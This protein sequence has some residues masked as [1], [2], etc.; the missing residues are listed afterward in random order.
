MIEDRTESRI[1]GQ[2]AGKLLESGLGFRFQAR[3]RSMLPTIGD[4]EILQVERVDPATIRVGDIVLFKE[5]RGFKAHRIIG[6]RKHV[7]VVRGDSSLAPD[8]IRESQIVGRVTAKQCAETGR[9]VVLKGLMPRVSYFLSQLK[10]ALLP[11]GRRSP[12]LPA[13]LKSESDTTQH[14]RA[15]DSAN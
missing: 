10:R 7:F 6:K 12:R 8:T 15:R 14:L 1:F 4:G 5:G 2:L 9:Q 11:V 3:G 13:V